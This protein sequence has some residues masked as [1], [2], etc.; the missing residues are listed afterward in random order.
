ME[1]FVY[2]IEHNKEEFEEIIER[3][4]TDE[5][6]EYLKSDLSRNLGEEYDRI[7]EKWATKGVE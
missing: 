7:L 1:K 3:K 6:F 5:D 4:L 2:V